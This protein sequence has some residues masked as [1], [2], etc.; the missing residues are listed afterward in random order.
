M[1]SA[2]SE[3]WGRSLYVGLP[4]VEGP[5]VLRSKQLAIILGRDTPKEGP[6]NGRPQNPSLGASTQVCLSAHKDK[7]LALE[8]LRHATSRENRLTTQTDT[9]S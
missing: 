4:Q 5:Q 2:A 9:D 8:Y 7:Q 6:L 3:S 1:V